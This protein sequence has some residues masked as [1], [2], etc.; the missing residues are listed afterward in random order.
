MKN[1]FY[2]LDMFPYPSGASLHVGHSVGYIAT[3][4]YRRWK[5]TKGVEVYHPFGFDSFGLPTQQYALSTGKKP[6]DITRENIVKF[7]EQINKL[8]IEHTDREEKT[9]YTSDPNY[10]KWTQWIFSEIFNS[11]YDSEQ[12]KARH[13]DT[14]PHEDKDNYRLAYKGDRQVNWCEAL[15]CVLANEEVIDGL[16]ERGGHPVEK[17]IMNQWFLRIDPYKKR[18]SDGL[19]NVEWANKKVQKNWIEDRLHDVSFSRQIQWGEPFPVINEDGKIK[20]LPTD[21]LPVYW[22]EYPNMESDV[23]PSFAGS[24]WYFFRYFDR[25]NESFFSNK[26]KQKQHLPVDIYVGGS[27]HTTGHVLYARFITK[28]LFDLGHSF[29]DEPFKRII[30]VGMML[31]ENGEKMSKSKNNYVTID[32]AVEKYGVDAFR[33]WISFIAPFEQTKVWKEDGIKGCVKFISRYEKLFDMAIEDFQSNKQDEL[34]SR[35]ESGIDRDI[36]RFSF[37]T[38]VPKLMTFVNDMYK[39]EKVSFSVMAYSLFV[40]SPFVPNLVKKLLNKTQEKLEKNQS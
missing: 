31:G 40:F 37:N 17:K 3:D 30:N 25:H 2:I 36:D 24:N 20:T 26:E 6:E 27:E 33:L 38:A 1:K 19:E 11:W 39:Q 16:S 4:I 15:G 34:I 21:Y 10:F 13:I 9:L 35:L 8:N 7:T 23:M 18:L 12:N 32:E 29:V 28:V 5:E 14:C 22:N